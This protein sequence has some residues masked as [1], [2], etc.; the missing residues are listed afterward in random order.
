LSL[1]PSPLSLSLSLYVYV[2]VY[3]W[4]CCSVEHWLIP[5]MIV[6]E[7]WNVSHKKK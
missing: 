6:N 1:S 3:Y 7:I 4:F 2:C 5:K